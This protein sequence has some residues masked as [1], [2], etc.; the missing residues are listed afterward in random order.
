[1]RDWSDRSYQAFT[2]RPPWESYTD[3][4]VLVVLM[5]KRVHARPPEI[6]DTWW[7]VCVKCSKYEPSERPTMATVVK[8][9][10]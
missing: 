4:G 3:T 5:E 10:A 1:M 6:D 7:N 9:L 8:E 2:R